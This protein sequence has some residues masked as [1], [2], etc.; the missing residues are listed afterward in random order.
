MIIGLTLRLVEV[1]SLLKAGVSST[2]SDSKG[3]G[4]VPFIGEMMGDRPFL[5][6]LV[7]LLLSDSST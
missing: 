1:S 3:F 2:S 6:R 4:E 7:E 5:K